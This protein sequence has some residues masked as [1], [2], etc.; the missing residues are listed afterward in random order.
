MA[1]R[2]ANANIDLGKI[3]ITY[4]MYFTMRNAD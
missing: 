4:K 3:N 2:A 1:Q